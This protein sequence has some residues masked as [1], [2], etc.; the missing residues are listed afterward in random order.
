[1]AA[2]TSSSRKDS[3]N[4]RFAGMTTFCLVRAPVPQALGS[5]WLRQPS[6]PLLK[7]SSFEAVPAPLQ[8]FHAGLARLI[9][10]IQLPQ[11]LV[12]RRAKERYSRNEF[13]SIQ[14]VVHQVVISSG[15]IHML[16]TPHGSEASPVLK[17]LPRKHSS[18]FLSF[19][20]VELE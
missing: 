15:K 19:T 11:K 7:K 1:L 8:C 3:L 16:L 9:D 4:F 13:I 5:C 14:A 20:R 2:R 17:Y 12:A 10:A 18:Y 6:Q